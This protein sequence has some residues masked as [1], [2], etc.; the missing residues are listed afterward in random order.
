MTVSE[1]SLQRNQSEVGRYNGAAEAEYTISS[2]LRASLTFGADVTSQK[3]YSFS[4]FGYNIDLFTG[5]T[6]DGQ[7]TISDR[8]VRVL[9]LDGKLSWNQNFGRRLASSFTTG[10][11][12]FNDRTTDAWSAAQTFPGPGIEVVSAGG[13]ARDFFERYL[14]TVNGGYFAQ[15]QLS[16]DEWIHATVGGRYDYSSAFGAEAPGVFYPKISLSVVPSDL[17]SWSSSMVSQ[18]RLR[19][20]IGQSGR[21]PGAFDRFT[22]F[23]PLTSELGAGLVPSQLGNQTLEPEISTEIEGGFELGLFANRVGLDVTYWNRRV[24]DLLVDPAVPGVQRVPAPAARQHRRDARQRPRDRPP[25]ARV[26]PR[27][28]LAG[29]VRQRG[30][31]QPEGDLARAARRRSRS[32]TSGTAG[33]SRKATRSARSTRRSS[34]RGAPGGSAA[35]NSAGQPIACYRD[36]EYPDLPQRE[37]ARGHAPGAPHVP[38]AAP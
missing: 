35:T 27:E 26:Q 8:D 3:D 9:T 4:P 23:A 7:R 2:A 11:Q 21:Q 32:A 20:A 16:L 31:P 6:P 5:Q 34:P 30:A 1:A 10:V 13:Q 24:E 19:A 18:L 28:R 36:G 17:K 22:T 33:S 25:R 37:R 15:E 38:R 12:V 14:T 29:A